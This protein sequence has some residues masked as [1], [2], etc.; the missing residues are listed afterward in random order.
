MTTQPETDI[1][2][3]ILAALN[4]IPCTY[5]RKTH[6]SRYSRDW[7]DIIGCNRGA[8]FALEVKTE[9]GSTTPK[10]E[11]ELLKWKLA[12]ARFGVVRSVE[13]ALAIAIGMKVSGEMVNG[14]ARH[15]KGFE[16]ALSQDEIDAIY[17]AGHDDG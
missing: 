16:R 12:G 3:A 11:R 9:T 8:M 10:Q 6:G 5:A 17:K 13:E 14:T 2:Q 7:P 1:A 4:A 15:I